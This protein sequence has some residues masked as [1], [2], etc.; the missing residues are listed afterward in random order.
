MK[1]LIFT[2]ALL[3]Q[4]AFVFAF[5]AP[6]QTAQAK[7]NDVKMYQQAGT[8]TEIL[9]ALQ[10]TDEVVIVRR[11]NA[12]WTIVTVNGQVGYVLT[13]ELTPKKNIRNIAMAKPMRKQTL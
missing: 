2:F 5:T 10:S 3:I 7:V 6:Q 12:D 4:T 13:S 1:K 9:K 8:S 11:H